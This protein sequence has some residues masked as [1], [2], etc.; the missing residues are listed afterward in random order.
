MWVVEMEGSGGHQNNFFH[1]QLIIFHRHFQ[2]P[3]NLWKCFHYQPNWDRFKHSFF[4]SNL[5]L[6]TRLDFDFNKQ[7]LKHLADYKRGE[8]PGLPCWI[9]IFNCF[10]HKRGEKRRL[11]PI[12]F[13]RQVFL[14]LFFEHVKTQIL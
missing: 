2:F 4:M 6:L 7:S 5:G 12:I 14:I 9:I 1:L 3:I 10:E 13:S 8:K 11:R